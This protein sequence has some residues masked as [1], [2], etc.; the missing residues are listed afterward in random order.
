MKTVAAILVEQRKPLVIDEVEVPALGYGQVLVQI[1][2]SRICGSQLGEIEG[3]KGPDRYLPHLLGHEAGATVLDVGPE[4]RHV[5]KGNLV[6]CHW[7]PGKGIEARPATY[8]WK[9]S[10]TN[11]GWIT[12]FQQYSVISENR[13]T[14]V[15]ADTDLELCCLLADTLTT[16]FGVISNDAGL[17]IG[18]SAVIIGCGGIGLGVVL[19]AKL[20]G[21]C[22]LIAVDLYDHKLAV[23]A[24]YG[25]T[26]TINAGKEDFVAATKKILDG[27]PAD[28]VVDG[29]GNA[30]ILEKALELAG[31]RGK[32]V[33]VGVMPHDRKL[34]LNTLQLH[35]GKILRGSHGGESHPADDIPR[36]LRMKKAGLFETSGFVSHRTRLDQINDAIAKMKSGE[37]IHTIIHFDQAA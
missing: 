8:D 32:V 19:G 28:V 12:T 26:H 15:P 2:A 4:V 35:M 3:V 24:K 23:A 36:I 29:T 16:G 1:H 20:A 22:P 5:K 21:A 25:A 27:L 11:A 17:K 31:P 34:S 33:G 13:L 9:G 14:P 30:A 37:S 18:E 10:K 7:R 6:V